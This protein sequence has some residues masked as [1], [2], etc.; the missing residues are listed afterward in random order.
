MSGRNYVIYAPTPWN[1]PRQPAHN[2]ADALAVSNDVL[3][4]DPR[5]SPLSPVRYGLRADTWRQWRLL[6]DRRV[7]TCG[8]VRVFTPLVLPPV[9]HPRMRELSIPLVRAQI[10]TAVKR[11][12]LARPVVLDWGTLP[13]VV[14]AVNEALHVGFVMDHPAA[15]ASLLDRN[16]ADLEA[17]V[18]TTCRAADLLCTTSLPMKEL[19]SEQ[20]WRSEL[21]PF[22]FPADLAGSFDHAV[23]PPEYA[24]LPHPLLGYTG[25]IDDRLDFELIV[26]LADKFSH[27]SV[28]FVGA[29]SP[30]LSK[31]A[32][33][34]LAARPNIHLLGPRHRAQLPAYIS[35]LDVALLPY[36]DSLFT[37]FQS[38]MKLWEYLYAGPPIV[39]T[40]SPELRQYS[41][42]FL[43]Y[44]EV[45]EAAPSHGGACGGQTIFWP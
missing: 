39:G 4:V 32:Q 20:G 28:V 45:P 37:R 42:A 6:V 40:G 14:G 24:E 2:L 12:G 44:A 27:G 22:G 33:A 36:K 29:P 30:R 7:R 19:L 5:I 11:A 31:Q 16:A 23:Q 38:P 9:Q 13:G 18:A 41:P 8:R 1:S 10:A 15:S 35:F 43:N 26:T 3:Y 25:S 21:V 17:D 34:A